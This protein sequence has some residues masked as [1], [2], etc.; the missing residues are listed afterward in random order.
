MTE[1]AF[2]FYHLTSRGNNIRDLFMD[3]DVTYLIK[4]NLFG[5]A[6]WSDLLDGKKQ[7]TIIWLGTEEEKA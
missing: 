6:L 7:H 1:R 3:P 2:K 4:T 5:I